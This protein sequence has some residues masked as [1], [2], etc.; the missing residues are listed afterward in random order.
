[1]CMC[2]CVYVCLY[3][4]VYAYV[5]ASVRQWSGRPGFNP[6]S[7]HTKDSKMVPDVGLLSSQHNKVR[8]KGKVEQTRK[9]VAP[10]LTSWC[11]S[12]WKGSLRV[13]L[14]YDRQIYLCVYMHMYFM[15][16]SS[17]TI[18]N[19]HTHTHTHTHIYIYIVTNFSCK[20]FFN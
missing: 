18:F 3:A 10:S 1:M 5:Y 9:G 8:I 6:K 17:Y 7:S 15:P 20:H 19:T 12:Y 4:C 16:N 13:T 14:D 2:M 11:S